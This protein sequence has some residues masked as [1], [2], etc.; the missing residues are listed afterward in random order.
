MAAPPFWGWRIRPT[1]S[2]L[3]EPSR[4]RD[5]IFVVWWRG[6]FGG[7]GRYLFGDDWWGGEAGKAPEVRS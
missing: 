2:L 3:A 1:P 6:R 5:I 7:K 4:P